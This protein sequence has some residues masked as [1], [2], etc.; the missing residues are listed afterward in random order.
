MRLDGNKQANAETTGTGMAPL[1]RK[2]AGTGTETPIPPP[3]PPNYPIRG[4][5]AEPMNAFGMCYY[6]DY[7]RRGQ[8]ANFFFLAL[9]LQ[10]MLE[11]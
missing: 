5:R 4:T 6:C 8:G 1:N 9:Q 11:I 10:S 3:S 2:R 7:V